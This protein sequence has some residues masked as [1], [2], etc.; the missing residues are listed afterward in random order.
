ME[1]LPEEAST[2]LE[3]IPQSTKAPE[4]VSHSDTEKQL[5]HG[6]L[7]STE[8]SENRHIGAVR[9]CHVDRAAELRLL[10]KLDWRIIP[11]CF[12]CCKYTAIPFSKDF[13][14]YFLIKIRSLELY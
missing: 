5:V 11:I 13:R 2:P 14:Q 9:P 6:E 12:T 1:S 4:V 8:G 7:T 3:M 10:K